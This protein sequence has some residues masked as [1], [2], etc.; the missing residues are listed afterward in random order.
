MN[1]YEYKLWINS[2]SVDQAYTECMAD[3]MKENER[4]NH[5]LGGMVK[6]EATADLSPAALKKRVGSTPTT[7][8]NA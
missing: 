6:Q 5:K 8:T 2:I 7:P 1:I 4:A 3:L